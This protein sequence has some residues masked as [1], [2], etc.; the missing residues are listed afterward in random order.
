M[1]KI[2]IQPGR[3]HLVNN[4]YYG[5]E[6]QLCCKRAL[7]LR[8]KLLSSTVNLYVRINTRCGLHKAHHEVKHCLSDMYLYVTLCISMRLSNAI[9]VTSQSNH[10]N[11]DLYTLYYSSFRLLNI[12]IEWRVTIQELMYSILTLTYYILIA[13]QQLPRP[14][15]RWQPSVWVACIK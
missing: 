12:L 10:G 9:C 3:G 6:S 15:P 11:K 2:T 4:T 13:P 8:G 7:Q 1:V 14:N 5:I